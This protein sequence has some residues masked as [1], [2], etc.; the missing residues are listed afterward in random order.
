MHSGYFWVVFIV[1]LLKHILC[2][3][4]TLLHQ[5]MITQPTP[6]RGGV[7]FFFL[8]ASPA[9]QQQGNKVPMKPSHQN[10]LTYIMRESLADKNEI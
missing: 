2:V 7:C 4:K 9:R 10:Y 5:T 1:Y 3:F 8:K 6:H